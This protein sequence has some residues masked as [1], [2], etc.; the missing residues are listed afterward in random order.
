MNT[1][2]DMLNQIIGGIVWFAIKFVVERGKMTMEKEIICPL[3]EGRCIKGRCLAY[4]TERIRSEREIRDLNASDIPVERSVKGEY[5]LHYKLKFVP[6]Y[7]KRDE[8]IIKVGE[9]GIPY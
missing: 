2:L 8:K 1:V 4:Q 5:C 3:I 7:E 6:S 9:V